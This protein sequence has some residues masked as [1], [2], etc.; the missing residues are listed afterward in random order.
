MGYGLT[1]D[2]GSISYY[3]QDVELAVDEFGPCNV[4]YGG[5]LQEDM[6]FC[7]SGSRPCS[8]TCSPQTFAAHR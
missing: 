1:S 4:L 7:V 2:G 3:L 5:I 8:I 6:Q